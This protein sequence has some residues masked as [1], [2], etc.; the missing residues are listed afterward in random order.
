MSRF[1]FGNGSGKNQITVSQLAPGYSILYMDRE[2]P[3]PEVLPY[4]L[5]Q[6]MQAWYTSQ[7]ESNPD[8]HVH[9][10]LPIVRGGNLIAVQVWHS[11]IT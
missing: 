11:K 3:L 5:N 2:E 10:V 1:D 9:A 6:V 8:F 4:G 7:L